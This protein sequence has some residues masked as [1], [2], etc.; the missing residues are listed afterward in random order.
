MFFAREKRLIVNGEII[1]NLKF[2]IQTFF[3]AKRLGGMISTRFVNGEI[4]SNLKFLIQT[5]YK[6]F[7]R[8]WDC[9]PR[10]R[11]FLFCK[12]F[13]FAA[14]KSKKKADEMY[15]YAMREEKTVIC[16]SHA[17]ND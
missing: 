3:K 12:A 17:K 15:R 10:T 11:R 9:V 7:G 8:V 16:F 2:L 13:F 14:A 4:I 1:S 6:K 5:F